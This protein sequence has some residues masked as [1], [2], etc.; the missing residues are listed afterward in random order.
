VPP[1]PPGDAGDVTLAI[2]NYNGRELLPI[3]LDSIAR[4]SATGFVVHVLDDASTDDSLDYL[5]EHWPDVRVFASP[6][7]RNVTASMARAIEL[8]STRYVALLNNDLELD[9]RW[10]EQMLAELEAHP[11]AASADC[12]M[13]GFHDR[14]TL[15]GAGDVM[16]R[17]G[18]P[19]RR[20]QGERDRGQYD[21]PGEV[22]SATGGAALYRREAF[23]SVGNFDVDFVAY[24]EDVDWGFRA[25]LLGMSTRYVPG[26]ISYHVG[27]AT[28]GAQPDRF[29]SLIVRNQLLVVIK[30]FPAAL[31]LRQ[32]HRIVFFE[33]K[34]FAFHTRHGHGRAHLRGLA[35]VLLALPATLRKRRAIQRA[36]TV[37]GRE[38]ERA[39]L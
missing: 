6:V 9:P 16:A 4:Q 25:R 34:W 20:G 5:A 38:I 15:D 35:G 28:T 33:L 1:N 19:R 37:S 39:L 13:L 18:Y 36:R 22:F 29:L 7:N 31:L 30:D 3:V 23:V 32:A 17:N 24:Y 10:L 2:L 27:S 26:A 11:E 8:A 14:E 12:K 21:A